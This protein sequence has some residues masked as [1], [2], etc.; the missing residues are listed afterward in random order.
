M[1]LGSMNIFAATRRIGPSEI[2][3]EG[4]RTSIGKL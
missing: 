3:F 4:A 1:R 2:T